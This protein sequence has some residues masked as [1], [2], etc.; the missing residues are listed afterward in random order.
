MATATIYCDTPGVDNGATCA[1]FCVGLQKKFCDNY[2]VK[3]DSQFIESLYNIIRTQGAMDAL[4]CEQ[5][6]AETSNQVKEILRHLLIK[7]WQTEPH[8]QNQNP[9]E[10]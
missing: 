8:F 10:R 5:D 7:E 1:Q 2:G 9:A 6:K 4:I 3:S